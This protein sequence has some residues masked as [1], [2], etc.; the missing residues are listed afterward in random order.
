MAGAVLGLRVPGRGASRTS[1]RRA[2]TLPEFTGLWQRHAR[3]GTRARRRGRRD[4]PA[5]P[6]YDEGDVRVR[7]NRTGYPAAH[8]GPPGARGR[9][10]RLRHRRS[11]AAAT[12][13]CSPGTTARRTERVV[14]AMKAR[15][16][17]RKSV[18]VGDDVALV[19]DLA[20]GPDALA[21]IVRVERRG[22]R[23]C[24]ARPTTPTR[25]ERVIV[26]NADQLVIVTALADPE[27]RP[28]MIDRC[29]VAAYDAGLDP[30]LVLT[31]ADLVDPAP[32]LAR[33]RA[34]RGAARRHLARPGDR[35]LRTG[36]TPLQRAAGPARS[37]SSSA[38]PASASPPWS[39]RLV[40][41]AGRATGRGQRR[42][43]PR[44]AHLVLGRRAARC[45]AT[46]AGSSTPPASAR[47]GW[48]T[49]T[50]ARIIDHFPDLEPGTDECPR[51]CTHDE[52][53]CALDAWVGRPG[54]PG[55]PL[56]A[57]VAAPA[58]ARPLRPPRGLTPPEPRPPWGGGPGPRLRVSGWCSGRCPAR[59]PGHRCG[60]RGRSTRSRARRHHG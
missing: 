19:G 11:T 17:G 59:R 54:R 22:G 49:S 52:A 13:A 26:A 31:K 9:R 35:A 58:A 1:P 30:L 21:R 33:L 16:L 29:L 18:V 44:A 20:G 7:P 36:W 46:T 43:R 50:P 27:P 39:T 12:R 56:P 24:G 42:D 25:C 48:R 32:F 15:E 23:C 45:P 40:P 5:G 3:R 51:G 6:R 10:R 14:T 8:Q 41:G 37:A 4:E 60:R 38:T 53:E 55:R 47:S 28:R 2:K 34:A 57:G